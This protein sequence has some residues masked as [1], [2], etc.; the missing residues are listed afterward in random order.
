VPSG[1]SAFAAC[2]LCNSGHVPLMQ[3]A[4]NE[5]AVVNSIWR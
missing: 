5:L 1:E 3:K 4:L 2:A